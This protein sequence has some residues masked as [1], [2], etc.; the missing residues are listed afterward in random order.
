MNSSSS[1][2]STDVP[3]FMLVASLL[4][5]CER[6]T[7]CRGHEPHQLPGTPLK[8]EEPITVAVDGSVQLAETIDSAATG[9]D[10]IHEAAARGR[11]MVLA[12]LHSGNWDL[13]GVWIVQRPAHRPSWPSGYNRNHCSGASSG[14]VKAWDSRSFRSPVAHCATVGTADRPGSTGTDSRAAR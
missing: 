3:S 4:S 9:L 11:G 2:S 6:P 1:P 8:R 13:A 5:R 14:F 7:A 10:H 12:L